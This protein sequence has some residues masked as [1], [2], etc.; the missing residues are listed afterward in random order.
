MRL[1]FLNMFICSGSPYPEDFDNDEELIAYLSAKKKS[2]ES[3]SPLQQ[4]DGMPSALPSSLEAIPKMPGSA[5]RVGSNFALLASI[6]DLLDEKFNAKLTAVEKSNYRYG[7]KLSTF[8]RF[9]RNRNRR[10]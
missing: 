2:R 9:R 5:D 8:M 1:Y 7:A 6:E 4:M 10:G 3:T